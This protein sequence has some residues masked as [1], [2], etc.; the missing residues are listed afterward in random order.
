MGTR[1]QML[2][3]AMADRYAYSS[4]GYVERTHRWEP[5]AEAP[6]RFT[7]VQRGGRLVIEEV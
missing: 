6:R 1:E 2:A 3:R 4:D 7:I 5:R